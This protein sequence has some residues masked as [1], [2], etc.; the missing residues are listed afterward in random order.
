MHARTHAT[1]HLC[2]SF[3]N[4]VHTHLASLNTITRIPL[5]S[6]HFERPNLS[7]CYGRD[8]MHI[9]SRLW[10][11]LLKWFTVT[12]ALATLQCVQSPQHTTT[13]HNPRLTP[14]CEGR[15]CLIMTLGGDGALRLINPCQRPSSRVQTFPQGATVTKLA[16]HDPAMKLLAICVKTGTAEPP[17]ELRC[18]D[19]VTGGPLNCYLCRDPDQSPALLSAV[20]EYSGGG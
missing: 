2:I 14:S 10:N 16:V 9:T 11:K 15:R 3:H 6:H 5:T 13:A 1:N 17:C 7:M 4:S 19:P 12:V 8:L 20:S 18:I